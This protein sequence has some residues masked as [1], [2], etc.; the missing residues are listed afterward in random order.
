MDE[1]V[2]QELCFT[3]Y[4]DPASVGKHPPITPWNRMK[5]RKWIEQDF[6]AS[7]RSIPAGWLP[8]L[9]AGEAY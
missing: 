4:L 1:V 3:R 5:V 7:L 2:R 9:G 8:R 6:P